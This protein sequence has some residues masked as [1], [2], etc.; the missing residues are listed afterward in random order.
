MKKI[1]IVYFVY[2]NEKKNYKKLIEGQLRDIARS[3]VFN[4]ADLYIQ[5][6][7]KNELKD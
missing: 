5:V 3:G 2:I 1:A 4:D 6:S 7:M